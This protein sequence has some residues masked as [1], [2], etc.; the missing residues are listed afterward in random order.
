MNLLRGSFYPLEITHKCAVSEN[1]KNV[2]LKCRGKLIHP[3]MSGE[4]CILKQRRSIERFPLLEAA[5]ILILTSPS[6]SAL[7]RNTIFFILFFFKFLLTAYDKTLSGVNTFKC[8][9]LSF[10]RFNPAAGDTGALLTPPADNVFSFLSCR[11]DSEEPSSV[12]RYIFFF[13]KYRVSVKR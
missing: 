5:V 7:V 11:D 9:L 4:P 2:P 3:L 10:F 6:I 13:F 8:R 12:V 1:V